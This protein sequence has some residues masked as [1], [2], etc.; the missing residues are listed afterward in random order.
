MAAGGAYVRQQVGAGGSLALHQRTVGQYHVHFVTPGIDDGAGVSN[1]QGCVQRPG[2]EVGH[3]GHLDAA[4]QCRARLRHEA[5]PHTDGGHGAVGRLGALA[6][7]VNV[8]AGVAS[9]QAGQIQTV[10]GQLG[11]CGQGKGVWHGFG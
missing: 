4:G 3:C 11:G 7:G 6:Q 8:G 10:Q 9:V 5:R 1:G 2:G